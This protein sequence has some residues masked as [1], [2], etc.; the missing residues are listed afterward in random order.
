MKAWVTK[1]ALTK[2]I[3]EKEVLVCGKG[4]VKEDRDGFPIYYHGLEW[5]STRESA[6]KRAEE[7]RKKKIAS[8]KKKIENLEK[9]KF[10]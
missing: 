7:M 10:D 3:L 1:Y 6:I 8:L 4:H 9:M 2:G 5:Q